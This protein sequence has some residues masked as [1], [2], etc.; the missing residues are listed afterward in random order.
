MLGPIYCIQY[1]RKMF[2]YSIYF[3]SSIQKAG[4]VLIRV[5]LSISL[6]NTLQLATPFLIILDQ[7]SI[8]PVYWSVLPQN[9]NK[10]YII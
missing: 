9:Q 4:D 1:S 6:T 3:V 7:P 2:S 5:S 8:R 10:L